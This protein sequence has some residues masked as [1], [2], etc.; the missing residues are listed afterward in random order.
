MNKSARQLFADLGKKI[1][2]T[3]DDDRE[4]AFQFQSE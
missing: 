3:S 1:S 2:S 4:E